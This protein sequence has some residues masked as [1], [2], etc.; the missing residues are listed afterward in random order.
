MA[1]SNAAPVTRRSFS[2]LQNPLEVPHLIDIQRRSFEELTDPKKGGAAGDD[3]RHL[4][5]RG[6]HGEPRDRLRRVQVRGAAALDRGVPREGHDLLAA[7]DRDRRLPEQGDRRDPRA[8]R[9][10]GRLPVDDRPRHLHH[11]RHRAR[12]RHPA[13]ALPRRLRDGAE[14][15]RETGLHRQPDAGPRLL[16]G[17][18]NRQKGPRLRPHRPQ[19]QTAG[20]GAAARDGL[21][22][23]REAPRR[24]STTRSTS[25]TRSRPTPRRPGPKR[26]P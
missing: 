25:G 3:R 24:C 17:A 4:P 20:H 11:Q 7:A 12:R 13:R 5:D 8:V 21:R 10:H 26:A 16:A 6:L 9:L 19:A 1:R 22:R 18:G 23:G 14:G 15:P 2:R